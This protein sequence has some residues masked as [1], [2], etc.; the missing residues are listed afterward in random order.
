MRGTQRQKKAKKV[1]KSIKNRGKG[2]GKEWKM[3]P[4]TDKKELKRLEE[5]ERIAAERERNDNEIIR[6]NARLEEQ[7]NNIISSW[8]GTPMD[9]EEIQ[10]QKREDEA[11]NKRVNSK[12]AKSRKLTIY[13]LGGSKRRKHCK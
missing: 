6:L 3:T 4:I 13:D 9:P 1:K 12:H 11:H 10:K 5:A 8:L 7:K 2:R